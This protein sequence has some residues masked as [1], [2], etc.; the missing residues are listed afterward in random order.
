MYSIMALTSVTPFTCKCGEFVVCL[1]V[2]VPVD[3]HLYLTQIYTS[4]FLTN[5]ALVE[6]AHGV[7][8][9]VVNVVDCER[10]Q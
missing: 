2:M 1:T 6:C 7:N 3:G 10:S 5:E 9:V 8:I 4:R